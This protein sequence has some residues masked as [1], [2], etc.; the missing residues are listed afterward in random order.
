MNAPS[1]PQSSAPRTGGKAA[2][3]PSDALLRRNLQFLAVRSVNAA[4]AIELAKDP[5]HVS[6]GV[7]MQGKLWAQVREG[8]ASRQTCSRF[9]SSSEAQ[10]WAEAIDLKSSAG[11]V[12]LG[13][14][15]GHHVASL[16]QKLRNMGAIIVFEPDV[17]LL[18]GVL[19]RVDLRECFGPCPVVMVTDATDGAALA[20]CIQG[21]EG[22][23]A[24]G[25]TIADHP[26]SRARLGRQSE[27]FSSQLTHVVKAVRTT[28]V[29]SLV[30]SDVTARNCIQNLG[31]YVTLPGIA[32]LSGCC[33]GHPA[34]VVSAGPSL[35][36][37]IDLLARPGIRDR[38]VII[39]VQTT[40]KTLLA[41]GI[42]PHFVVAIDYHEISRRFYEGLT[43][44]DVEGVTL[45]ADSKCNPVI[46][47]SFPGNI[48]LSGED[49]SDRLA[50]EALW[51]DMG[52]LTPGSTVAHLAY[53]LA[54]FLGCD[55]VMMIGQDLGFTDHQYYAPGAAIHEAWAGELSE[56]NT[57]EMLEWQ[58]IA[59]MRSLLRKVSDQRGRRMYTDE[60][61]ATYLVQFERDFAKDA[62][63][64][65]C[66]ID[67]TEGGVAKAHTTAMP[68]GE[69]LERWATRPLPAIPAA[70]L[71]GDSET[72]LAGARRRLQDLRAGAFD[73]EKRSRDSG[74]ALREMLHHHSDQKRVN[75]L[76][77]AVE[78][79]ARKVAAD[80]AF[81]LVNFI[82]QAG[83][84]KR[85]KA[86]RALGLDTIMNPMERQRAQIERDVDNVTWLGDVARYLQRLLDDGLAR[87]DGA[88]PVT[89][90]PSV[91]DEGTVVTTREQRKVGAVISVLSESP[92]LAATLARVG[93]ATTLSG[94]TLLVAD[95]PQLVRF[96]EDIASR[97]KGVSV[98][99]A[100]AAAMRS[101]HA[102]VAA[103]RA[104]SRH[105]WRG[106]I[107]NF[108]IY[109]EAYHPVPLAA[110]MVERD[111]DAAAIIDE[112]WV[113]I[114]PAL[115]DSCVGR[116][117]ERPDTYG[118]TFTQAAPGLG[119]C[120]LARRVV[121][122]TAS[123]RGS[124]ASIGG[125]LAYVPVAPQADPISKPVCPAIDPLVRDCALRCTADTQSAAEFI[126][127]LRLDPSASAQQIAA[128]MVAAAKSVRWRVEGIEIRAHSSTPCEAVAAAVRR[129][130]A[131]DGSV[132][133]T[134]RAPWRSITNFVD[135]SL[136]AGASTVHVRTSLRGGVE[137]AA[138]LDA[139]RA[140]VIS[141][142]LAA[143][144]EETYRLIT[145]RE[146]FAAT[147]EGG[148]LLVC[149][150]RDG[151]SDGSRLPS[152]WIVPRVTRCDAVL[153]ELES[154]YDRWLM[155]AGAC[156]IDP[157]RTDVVNERIAPL[158]LPALAA[159]RARRLW[160]S[161]DLRQGVIVEPHHEKVVLT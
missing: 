150:A 83:Q 9:D 119:A 117:V 109:D 139:S 155:F 10:A 132:A 147:R 1:L 49:V 5:T 128:A 160:A 91:A 138:A 113:C 12:V 66:T 29:T 115:I 48:R 50:G 7:D 106:G 69:A 25:I 161:I 158:P 134:L 52:R 156:V 30:Q 24:S 99:T 55:P 153:D 105:C 22:T 124:H 133:V 33:R 102:R 68:L 96:A 112:S 13:F 92:A 39:A 2:P 51:R 60:Q 152:R 72:R 71:T 146:D 136:E 159:E 63:A 43:A 84:L 143:D 125:L 93:K 148:E 145:D 37:N 70:T 141:L 82:N 140:H 53:Y 40:L 19:Q 130:T 127:S 8:D 121:E 34:V 36:R 46:L 137:E 3:E 57:L 11:I 87:L 88:P 42:K 120:I 100:D 58:R 54:R 38:V 103:A 76:I 4:K 89:R 104:W 47:E 114:D 149:S 73:I 142:D 14:G 31:R 123:V 62:A 64:G 21:F 74:A 18:R 86:D 151:E 61:M 6:F 116:Y 26:P 23:L 101:R 20:S 135:A 122:E 85:F 118:I 41:K 80:P 81:W 95:E 44:S 110:A 79:S 28:V 45:V 27:S 144:T 157:P 15:T 111:L 129:F 90:D 98:H 59:R 108:T 131:D 78:A 67:A 97:I 126:A 107:A 75:K 77:H 65:L 16:A 35:R 32:E 17:S 56:F 94:I 154:F